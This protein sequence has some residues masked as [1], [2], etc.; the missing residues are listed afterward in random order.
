MSKIY[1]IYNCIVIICVSTYCKLYVTY[2]Q[3]VFVDNKM[4]ELLYLYISKKFLLLVT[5]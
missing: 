4:V 5:H 1:K 3:R 2:T